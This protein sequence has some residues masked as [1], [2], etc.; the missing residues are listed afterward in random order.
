MR[1]ALQIRHQT[2]NRVHDELRLSVITSR[3]VRMREVKFRRG[4]HQEP[5]IHT[6]TMSAY[7]GPGLRMRTRG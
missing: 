3:D 1:F 7:A 6:D 2:L 5:G 4:F